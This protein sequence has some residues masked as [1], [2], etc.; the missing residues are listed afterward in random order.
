MKVRSES[1]GE[2]EGGQDLLGDLDEGRPL[3]GS[4]YVGKVRSSQEISS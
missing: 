2:R 4:D 3:M 1:S